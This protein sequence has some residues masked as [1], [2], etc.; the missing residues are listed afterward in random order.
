MEEKALRSRKF[1]NF[2]TYLII[3]FAIVW[4]EVALHIRMQTELQ[5]APIYIVF[6]ISVGLFLS[7]LPC[8]LRGKWEKGVRIFI[9]FLV[10]LIFAAESIGYLI[11]Q[12]YYPASALGTAAENRLYDYIDII[13]TT[14]LAELPYLLLLMIPA[15]LGCIMPARR[16]V[17]DDNKRNMGRKSSDLR[18]ERRRILAALAIVLILAVGT[19]IFGRWFITLDWGGGD[20]TP[21]TLYNMDE[22]LDLQVERIGLLTM[23]RL[24]ILHQAF[25]STVAVPDIWCSFF[26]LIKD[27]PILFTP[28]IYAKS[29]GTTIKPGI[30]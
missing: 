24:D 14:V 23:L 5:F 2:L 16:F 15:V 11:L 22:N 20:F 30:S 12:T 29:S 7:I 18:W 3:P 6:S 8:I 28:S 25:P 21:A 1:I 4:M 13:K 17:Y 27:E 10:W 19:H 26:V 9:L